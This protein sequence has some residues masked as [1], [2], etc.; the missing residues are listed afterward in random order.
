L[1]DA[2]LE[3]VRLVPNDPDRGARLTARVVERMLAD[4][5]NVRV[6]TIVTIESDTDTFCEGLDLEGLLEADD[7]AKRALPRFG[8][9]LDVLGSTPAPVIALVRGAALAGGLGLAAAADHVIATPDATFGLPEVLFGLVPARVLPLVVRRTG[10]AR[11]RWLAMSGRTISAAEAY[12][13]GLVDEVV[14]DAATTLARVAERLVR[15]SAPAVAEARALSIALETAPRD[16]R[17]HAAA[18]FAR[19]LA[20]ADARTRIARW[21]AGS[22]P[23]PDSETG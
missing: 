17:E 2:P 8:E 14:D 6:G 3:R 5:A 1:S 12:D 16:Y 4:L 9:L 10:P 15:M 19:L 21:V 23:W 7:E 22:T 11:A 18:S 13:I 20:G